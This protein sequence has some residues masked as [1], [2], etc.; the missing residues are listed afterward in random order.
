VASVG[1]LLRHSMERGDLKQ[2]FCA[3]KLSIFL[4]SLES[5]RFDCYSD[6]LLRKSLKENSVAVCP[7][8][9]PVVV[10]LSSIPRQTQ[11]SSGLFLYCEHTNKSIGLG[12]DAY[13]LDS[14]CTCD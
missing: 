12:Y 8:L 14:G 13:L 1:P 6:I 9:H 11:R 2:S 10:D 7:P 4:M 5:Y 3:R